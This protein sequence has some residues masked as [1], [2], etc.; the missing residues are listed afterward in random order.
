MRVIRITV[1]VALAAIAAAACSR[2]PQK[3]SRESIASG[4]RYAADKKFKE[5]VVEYRAAIQTDPRSGE[6]RLKLADAYLQ[7]KDIPNA[8]R[9]TIRAAD[10]L[11]DNAD[12]QLKA[13]AFLMLAQKYEDARTRAQSV[14]AKDPRNVQAQI[15]VGNA[16]AGMKDFDAAVADM[17]EAI[18][19][20]PARANTYANLGMLQMARGNK[21]SAE[22][23]FKKAVEIDPKS[24]PARLALAN[25]YAASDQRPLAEQTLKDA[26]ALE[27]K[28]RLTNRALALLAI[29]NG[30][31]ADA[32]PYL[33]TMAAASN[34]P[35]EKLSVADYYLAMGRKDDAARLL[36]EL[37][38]SAEMYVP[39]KV[40]LATLA[41]SQNERQRA[42]QI[43][44]EVL[45][46][47][48]KAGSA[49][50][51]KARLLLADGKRDQALDKAKAAVA[52]EPRLVPAQYTL[53]L[54]YLALND[55]DNAR[56]AF[57]ETLKLNPRAAAA[58]MQLARIQ[59]VTG[60]SESSGQ[61]AQD[62]LNADP[63]NPT[64]RLILVRSLLARGD[65]AGAERE[66]A[67][68]TDKYP[69][70]SAVQTAQGSLALLKRDQ[71][72]ARRA[73]LRAAETDARNID[74]AR[75]LIM[76]DIAEKHPADARQRADA[77]VKANPTNAAALTIAA[78]AYRLTGDAARAEDLLRQA[79]S[80]APNSLSA[81]GM[82]GQLYAS[83]RKLEA[84][85]TEY[86]QIIAREPKSVSAHTMLGMLYDMDNK[87]ADAEKAYEAALA[88]D[89]HA[90]VAANNLAWLYV[91]AN[92]NLD[93][94]L[95]LAQ[96]AV[97]ALPDEPNVNDTLG[98]IYY[99]KDMYPQA[100][101]SLRHSVEKDPTNVSAQYHLGLTCVRLNDWDAGRKALKE[102][103]RLNPKFEGAAEAQKTLA[104]IGG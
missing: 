88:L 57:E 6:A 19:L 14:L 82:L 103:L 28:N 66:L 96:T 65:A 2:D 84:A 36:E 70:V 25:Y 49:L 78:Q 5:A 7:V 8:F 52:A 46:R 93:Q 71:P 45:V 38:A 35:S 86:Q 87:P 1:I 67:P 50:E 73:F 98:W 30:K 59:L 34:Q 91:D 100:L 62:V 53:G 68:L 10:L 80:S 83:Q 76:L 90:A 75:G 47:D 97:A 51:L 55:A 74:A 48:A 15:L 21:E 43:V 54:T 69:N 60:K 56:K 42:N 39:A 104:Q 32:E 101:A 77:M 17:E 95:Q 63:K 31:P 12:A 41:A 29:A 13:A 33:Q 92:R 79:I 16:T 61:Y 22:A 20:E 44:D 64:A 81:Y 58:Q 3:K 89:G 9:E 102:A 37:A 40:R 27:P 85:R 26:L 18:R 24:V 72:A 94:A 99:K 23:A 11:P 4:D